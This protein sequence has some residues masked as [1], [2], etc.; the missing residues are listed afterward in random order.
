M[1]D[2][3][4]RN[5][6]SSLRRERSSAVARLVAAKAMRDDLAVARIMVAEREVAALNERISRYSN[7]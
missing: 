1:M 3:N 7:R 4:L 5:L 2:K 6:V